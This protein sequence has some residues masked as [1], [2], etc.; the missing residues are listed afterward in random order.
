MRTSRLLVVALVAIGLLA[1]GATTASA[2]DATPVIA[3]GPI[4]DETREEV[5]SVF[6][7]DDGTSTVWFVQ[8][9]DLAPGLHGLQLHEVGDCSADLTEI[10][11]RIDAGVLP[12]LGVG[13]SGEGESVV[14]TESN[15]LAALDDTD[16][17]AFVVHDEPDNRANIPS[18]YQSDASS[19][20][21]PDSETLATGARRPA[22][23]G[24]FEMV[25]VDA[26]GR[27]TPIAPRSDLRS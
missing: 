18:R 19:D 26:D 11:E 10:G 2:A 9:S 27:P 1:T 8:A 17:V 4:V 20:T 21:G 14:T 25:A 5:G 24:R 6:A 16:G 22:L 15:G 7:I 3:S 12:T 13:A 23:S